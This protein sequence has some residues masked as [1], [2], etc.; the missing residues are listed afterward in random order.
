MG[1]TSALERC[2]GVEVYLGCL[3]VKVVVVVVVLSSGLAPHQCTDLQEYG[4]AGA[5]QCAEGTAG[6]IIGQ[7]GIKVWP[8]GSLSQWLWSWQGW[9]GH[10]GINPQVAAPGGWLALYLS[11]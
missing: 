3:S 2:R 10:A 4:G 9:Q 8:V 7:V 5:G 11:S 1:M 6:F